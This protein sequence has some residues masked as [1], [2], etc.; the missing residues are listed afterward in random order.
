[1]S[2]FLLT[3][4]MKEQIKGGE[5]VAGLPIELSIAET[6]AAFAADG[7]VSWQD[8][9]QIGLFHYVGEELSAVATNVPYTYNAQTKKFHASGTPATWTGT[10][11]DTHKV[12]VY[13]PYRNDGKADDPTNMAVS[14][15]SNQECDAAASEWF[16]GS[17]YGF[18][19]SM[20]ESAVYGQPIQLDP[21]SQYLP[22]LRFH[23]TNNTGKDMVV[24]KIVVS[25]TKMLIAGLR[26]NLLTLVE[27]KQ[28]DSKKEVTV[29]VKNG[30]LPAGESIDV[31]MM[32]RASDFSADDFTVKVVSSQ[33]EHP[34]VTFKGKKILKGERAFKNIS[35]EPIPEVESEF[36]I[37]DT[38][39]GGILYWMSD[40]KTT[41]KVLYPQKQSVAWSS[42]ASI[43]EIFLADRTDGT[44][45]VNGMK[46]IDPTLE[47]FPAAK[48]CE[49]LQPAGSWYLPARD[50][51][52]PLISAF[53]TDVLKETYGFTLS[54]TS[55]GANA[56]NSARIWTSE[57][58]SEGNKARF[59]A[60][61]TA[62]GGKVINAASKT[63]NTAYT[64]RCIKK[65]TLS[66]ATPEQGGSDLGFNEAGQ[67]G[68]Y[69]VYLLIGQSNMA[70]RGD[71]ISGDENSIEGAYLLNASG[72]VV[73]ANNPLNQY[74]TVHKNTTQG[75]NPG[76]SFVQKIYKETG[77]KVLLVV[78]A[79][80]GSSITYWVKSKLYNSSSDMSNFVVAGDH[81]LYD[82]AVARAKQ[83]MKYG[84][85]KGIL[86]HQGESDRSDANYMTKLNAM[87]AS[88][89]ADL[90]YV[91]FVAGQ[92]AT[93]RE[94]SADFNERLSTI[95]SVIQNADY[96]S[97]EIPEGTP[98]SDWQWKDS[99]DPHFSRTA[100]LVLGE[101]YA[102]KV[103]KMV[104]NK[105]IQ[106]E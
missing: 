6:K 66:E 40:D 9:D 70:G 79:R 100:Q 29:A 30:T 104:Y 94:G 87:V 11:D 21:L 19:T 62:E 46:Q 47:S 27:S 7:T 105:D 16:L 72:S 56:G 96:I 101:R 88:L 75:I 69:D 81:Y 76:F 77:R 98:L 59:V 38:V 91:P 5:S 25:C 48:Y 93:W 73:P 68:G 34:E 74:S 84:T 83:A 26:L 71:L 67:E 97:S 23:L 31:M 102:Q 63:T 22:V 55:E 33:G 86:W 35:V 99:S 106:V 18:A 45:N 95:S 89:R 60:I 53:G 42:E 14:M 3:S 64:V 2:G 44:I 41:G 82:E 13:Y 78:N 39:D 65:V 17:K 43:S 36:S 8:G 4:C 51:F 80:G 12:Y 61:S 1:M 49:D 20:N 15:T 24:S 32:F 52:L 92:I 28:S 37:G 50:E 54:G 90:G 103:L 58:S 57:S 85:L 10:A